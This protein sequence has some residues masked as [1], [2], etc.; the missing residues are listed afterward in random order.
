MKETEIIQKL[1]QI[2]HLQSLINDDCYLSNEICDLLGIEKTKTHK[3]VINKYLTNNN[4]ITLFP[5]VSN[6]NSRIILRY[7]DFI[8]NWWEHPK[9]YDAISDKLKNNLI[10]NYADKEHKIG[11]YVVAVQ[12]H[13]R[14]S[15]AN[16]VK[17]HIILWE[18]H[19]QQPFPDNYVM[20]PKD[21]NFL[22]LIIDNFEI[23][24]NEDHRSVVATGKRNHFYTTGTA[25]GISYKGGWKAIAKKFKKDKKCLVCGESLEY[26]LNVHHLI[27]YYLFDKPKDAHFEENLV[28][29]CDTCHA[30]VHSKTLNLSGF[31][32]EKIRLNLLEL[33][34]QL[35]EKFN[36]TE[37]KLLVDFSIESISSQVS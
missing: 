19:N 6:I 31:V 13:P 15:K 7:K 1:N 8:K 16:Q 18:L 25:N 27:S 21:G 26:K 17:A 12:N 36:N 3:N 22:N 24:S 35:K 4:I 29:L 9:L 33:L 11:R 10:I 20:I 23:K 30:K 14:A 37:K 2:K 28:C 32:S 34:G 5:K